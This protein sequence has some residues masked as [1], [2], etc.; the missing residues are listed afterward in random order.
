[1]T[2]PLAS[3]KILDFSTLLPGPFGSM[4]LADLG[5]EVLRV[6]APHRP[7]ITRAF[8]PLEGGISAWHALLNRSK[9]SIALNL[10]QPEAVTVVKRLVQNYDIVLEQFRPGVMDR[11]G[12]G[13]ETL[14]QVNPALIYCALTGYGQ[15]GPYRDRA[16]HDINYL[17][18]AGVMSHTGRKADGPTP[19][20]VQIADVGGGSF[21]AVM[22]ILAA[23]IHRQQTG[24]GQFVD[25]SMFDTSLAWNALASAQYLVGGENP[26]PESGRLNGGSF[27]DFYATSDGRYLSVG[28]LEPKFWRSFCQAIERPDLVEQGHSPDL[29]IQQSLKREIQKTIAARPLAAWLDIFAEVDA[30]VEPVLT[31]EEVVEHP[32]TQA[33]QMLVDV[34]RLDGTTQRQ[35]ASPYKFS[36]S[37]PAY[38]HT[39]VT[40]GIHTEEVLTEAGYNSAEIAELRQA[41]TFGM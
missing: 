12:V 39:G 11:L 16:G 7:D 27:Y 15:T 20:G 9:R 32:Q 17:S 4:I 6:E 34:P 36:R 22:G 25:I 1:M 35:V 33:R 38:K 8:P 3:L 41:G 10:K 28:S 18:L 14:Q 26:E 5:A 19:L 31:V 23:V 2:G 21:G 37:Q 29:E 13:Y 30:C 40:L 24:E